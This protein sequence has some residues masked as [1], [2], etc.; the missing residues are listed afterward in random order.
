M[1]IEKFDSGT[2]WPKAP[3]P[4]I[5]LWDA[6][7]AWKDVEPERDVW[8][9]SRLD[10]YVAAA[11]QHQTKI[12]YTFGTTPQ[13]A[14]SE[15]SQP[16]NYG[17]GTAAVPA[18]IRDWQNFVAA[19]ASRYLGKI[20]AYEILNEP[21]LSGYFTGGVEDQLRL[22]S[23]A[24]QTIKSIDPHAIVLSPG[25][26]GPGFKELDQ[27]LS[28][29]ASQYFDAIAY[30][31]YQFP[32]YPENQLQLISTVTAVLKK[33]SLNLPIW[34][35]EIGFGPGQTFASD[36]QQAAYFART[37]LIHWIAGVQHVF[38]YA[39]DDHEWVRLW[40]TEPDLVTLTKAGVAYGVLEKW[41]TGSTLNSC[42][43]NNGLHICSLA[44]ASGS[45]GHLI[46][47]TAG[48]EGFTVP[49]DWSASGISALDG[50]SR[51]VGTTIQ[52]GAEP[53]LVQ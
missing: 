47:L 17:P 16:G 44:L 46:W 7:V 49:A 51:Q 42:S 14:S 29:G 40:L 21:N 11:Q 1:T 36:D 10:A 53:V 26:Q 4:W 24:Y 31:F 52:L 45:Q 34:D 43:D 20:A 41:I 3:V 32:A 35:T 28:M 18:N 48:T 15:P 22:I 12:L 6:R 25:Y 30:H 37:I 19:I 13:W 38:W 33:Y 8:D 50:T 5:R 2:P 9:F 39:W 23:S 27:L